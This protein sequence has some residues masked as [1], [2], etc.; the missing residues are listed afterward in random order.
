[1]A[2]NGVD[3]A[4]WEPGIDWGVLPADFVIVKASQGDW[5][6]N[7]E[8]DAQMGGASSSNRLLGIYHYADARGDAHQQA[9]LFVSKAQPWLGKATLWLDWEDS[10]ILD[11]GPDW[12]RTFIDDV[13]SQTGYATVGIYMSKS[14]CN[15]WDWS[16]LTDCPL[17]GAQYATDDPTYGYQSDPWQSAQGWG[18]WGASPTIFQYTGTG[19][20]DGFNGDIDLNVAYI[21]RE[22]WAAMCGGAATPAPSPV[23]G[24]VAAAQ[25]KLRSIR[26]ARGWGGPEVDGISG[27]ESQT[28]LIALW[29]TVLNELYP[30]PPTLDT[31][32]W[33]GP[34]TREVIDYH[35]LSVGATGPETTCLKIALGL[36]GHEIVNYDD[37]TFD[38]SDFNELMGHLRYHANA[39]QDGVVDST[40]VSSLLPEAYVE[41]VASDGTPD[42]QGSFSGPITGK[43]YAGADLR[44]DVVGL[45]YHMV[46]HDGNDGHGYTWGN[47]WGNGGTEVVNVNGH[48]YTI[49]KGDR[50]CSSGV[51]SAYEAVGVSCGGATYTGNMADLMCATGNFKYHA[52]DDDYTMR[53]GDL[54]LN[55]AHHVAMCLNDSF[56]LMQFSIAENGTAY[57][58]QGDQ[59][60][61]E[62]NIRGYYDYPWDC[63]LEFTPSGSSDAPKDDSPNFAAVNPLYDGSERN[64]AAQRELMNDRRNYFG[65]DDDRVIDGIAGY[66]T[67]TDVVA[68]I[69]QSL[70]I[71]FPD[72]PPY[73]EVDGLIGQ[74]TSTCMDYHAVSAGMGDFRCLAVKYALTFNGYQCD[75]SNWDFTDADAD[76]LRQFAR[77]YPQVRQDGVCDGAVLRV[78]LPLASV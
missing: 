1:M 51:I 24:P 27:Q 30:D 25:R 5:Y 19:H 78:L 23:T 60:G 34:V 67:Q 2:L 11:A 33:L 29:Q 40:V 9:T 52:W 7:P 47:R 45:M 21:S 28:D 4:S 55:N 13:K 32:G 69:Q 3:I 41:G 15:R 42:G 49:A 46:T 70:N 64:K 22:Q 50:D 62:S 12:C 14:V 44:A 66:E 20:L 74:L 56:D 65:W 18:A 26:D 68:I 71:D 37:E 61:E 17:W 16:G 75:L 35:T 36:N 57:G 6:V 8:Y 58:V 63:C 72:D 54:A 73:L 31:D 39:R 48:D 59:T 38:K 10:S 53:P 76:R 77:W 43:P